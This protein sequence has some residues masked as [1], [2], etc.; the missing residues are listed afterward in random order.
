MAKRGVTAIALP[1]CAVP[2]LDQVAAVGDGRCARPPT[3]RRGPLRFITALPAIMPAFLLCAAVNRLPPSPD[4]RCNRR[5]AV[6][7]PL[8]AKFI[9]K[10]FGVARGVR[11]I[12]EFLLLDEGVFLQP[13]Q[14]L[15]AVGGDHLGLRIMDVRVDEARHDQLVGKVLDQNARPEAL[16]RVARPVPQPR[17]FRPSPA[18]CRRRCRCSFAHRRRRS[19]RARSSSSRPRIARNL[20]SPPQINARL[21]NI[22]RR[23]CSA[24][25]CTADP[26][27][28]QTLRSA[29]IPG[30][31]RNTPLR[32]VLRCA[33]ETRRSSLCQEL[34]S[35]LTAPA[36]RLRAT[37]RA[38]GVRRAS[39]Q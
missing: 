27:L 34:H 9:E 22:S 17:S 29:T 19:A 26:G 5:T 7:V 16:R 15:R 3:A 38:C 28:L 10:E 12:G 6:V 1:A 30:Q 36:R 20:F 23:R 21:I 18:R 8:R 24:K 4:E 39:F 31:Q 13:F 14:Q 11:R 32:S 2:A 37:M 35:M 33:R 25:R